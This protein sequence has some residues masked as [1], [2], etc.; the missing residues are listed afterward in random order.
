MICSF[1]HVRATMLHPGMRTSSILNTLH[2]ATCRNRVAKLTHHICA[3]KCWDILCFDV[4]IVWP[5]LAKTELIML[6]YHMLPSFGVWLLASVAC[7]DC[8]GNYSRFIVDSTGIESKRLSDVNG[9]GDWSHCGGGRVKSRFVSF[10]DVD[11][12]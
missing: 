8:C 1:G 3:Q 2:V 4:A 5:E 6:R 12:S 9:D 10:R 11:V 7:K